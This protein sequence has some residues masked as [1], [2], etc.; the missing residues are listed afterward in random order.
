MRP[1]IGMG[2]WTFLK[3]AL[4]LTLLFPALLC[5]QTPASSDG[6]EDQTTDTLQHS[7]RIDNYTL[8][9]NKGEDRGETIYYFKCW[10]CHNKYTKSAPYLKD[11]FQR[12]NLSSGDRVDEHTVA[13]KIKEGGSRMPAF[14]YSLTDTDISDLMAYLHSGK[15]CV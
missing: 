6:G 3:T 11:L 7:V 2:A 1:N 13:A 15:C 12:E 8:V 14:Q 4:L 10:M 9:G 5:A